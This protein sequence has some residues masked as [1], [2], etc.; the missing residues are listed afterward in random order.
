MSSILRLRLKAFDPQT[1][2]RDDCS[3]NMIHT[4][5][6]NSSQSSS[7]L[8]GMVIFTYAMSFLFCD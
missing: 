2:Y 6:E 7:Q 1:K 3:E 8:E 4:N 5:T